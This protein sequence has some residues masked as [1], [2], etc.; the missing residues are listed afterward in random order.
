MMR[1]RRT[2]KKMMINIKISWTRWE[3][4]RRKDNQKIRK[5]R[6]INNRNRGDGKIKKKM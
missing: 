4:K 5:R 6:K 3:R 1:I 2:S